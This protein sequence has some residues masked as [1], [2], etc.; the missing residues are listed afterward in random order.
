ME[1]VQLGNR[2]DDDQC[3]DVPRGDGPVEQ[4]VGRVLVP[5]DEEQGRPLGVPG[6][7]IQLAKQRAGPGAVAR[8]H[9]DEPVQDRTPGIVPAGQDHGPGELV[10]GPIEIAGGLLQPGQLVMRLEERGV[11]RDGP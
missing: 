6:I 10:A 11:E 9:P 4:G 7:A 8:G 1:R 5:Q 3:V 2:R